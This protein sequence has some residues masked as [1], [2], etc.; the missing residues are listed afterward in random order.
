MNEKQK[1]RAIRG[2]SILAKG[3]EPKI[4]DTETFLVPSQ[5]SDKKYRVMHKDAW[6]CECSDYYYRG[7]EC[8]HIQSV[9]FWIQLREKL[10]SDDKMEE[11]KDE[12]IESEKCV[13]CSS[14]DV[15]KDGVRKN[16]SGDKQ[17]FLCRSCNRRFILDIVKKTKGDSK[18][19]TMVIDLYMKG[20]SLRKIQDHLEQ[21]YG[22]DISHESIR[23]WV[24]RFTQIMNDYVKQFTP[25]VS[26]AW[27][28]DE[29]M[30]KIHG[31]WEWC[32]NALD[33]ETRFLIANNIT[34]ERTIP[35]AREIFSKAKEVAKNKPEFIITDGL[36]SYK[37]AIIK[38]FH[39]WRKPQVNHV[40]LESIRSKRANNNLVE[41]YHST[42]RERDKVMRGFKTEDTAKKFSEGYRTYYN[43]VRKHQ[44]IDGKT[45][46]EMA[47]LGLGLNRNRW[48]SLLRQSLNNQK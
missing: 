35:E 45:P 27:H 16:K 28:V 30:I 21:F 17:K 9:K 41:R 20:L 1:S 2:Y 14:V 33:E 18:I 40:K 46:S 10:D 7:L 31:K 34:K 32:W 39:S 47:D 23:R 29:Q 12:L 6:T 26:D 19:I 25:K 36:P 44:G 42:F 11:K 5:S 48:L 13:Y 38:E 15:V 37:E 4:I 43:F 22:L 3:V 24:V 8:K